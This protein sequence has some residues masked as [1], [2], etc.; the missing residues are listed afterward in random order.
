ML[1]QM[2]S[3]QLITIATFKPHYEI[4]LWTKGLTVFRNGAKL[5]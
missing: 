2:Y 3:E 4:K 5:Q 1:T